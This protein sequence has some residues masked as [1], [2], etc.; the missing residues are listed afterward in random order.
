MYDSK[1]DSKMHD[2][3]IP[4]MGFNGF[5]H[6]GNS[7]FKEDFENF[8]GREGILDKLK[9]WI[10]DNNGKRN[11][12]YSGAYLVTGFR[13]M[14]KSTFVHK[15][16]ND[17]IISFNLNEEYKIKENLKIKNKLNITEINNIKSSLHKNNNNFKRKIRN[18][19]IKKRKCWIKILFK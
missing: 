6:A 18:D 10:K 12:N 5:H 11:N 14:G 1:Y 9:S 13:G 4:L 19:Q 17:I 3:T 8:I 7:E 16:I 15:S 2:I